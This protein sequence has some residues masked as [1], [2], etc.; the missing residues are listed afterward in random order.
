MWPPHVLWAFQKHGG[1][2]PRERRERGREKKGDGI[3]WIAFMTWPKFKV[4]SLCGHFWR[5]PSAT[6]V[7]VVHVIPGPAPS[8]PSC[9]WILLPSSRHAVPTMAHTHRVG[10]AYVACRPFSHSHVPTQRSK[11]TTSTGQPQVGKAKAEKNV[12]K[13]EAFQI[14]F[15]CQQKQFDVG[16]CSYQ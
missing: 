13:V 9:S 6:Y 3:A 5:L 8:P 14:I 11:V 4:N 2:G 15:P 7:S 10:G 12:G 16:L 1:W